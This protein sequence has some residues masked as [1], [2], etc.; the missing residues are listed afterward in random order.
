MRLRDRRVF[1]GFVR[2]LTARKHAEQD[3]QRADRLALVGQLA[4]GLAHEIGTP[5]NVIAGNAELLRQAL[6]AQGQA[7]ADSRPSWRRL[8]ALPT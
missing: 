4:S 1:T 3:M 8:T 6:L 5:L 2:D 7:V